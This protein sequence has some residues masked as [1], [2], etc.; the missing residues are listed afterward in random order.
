MIASRSGVPAVALEPPAGRPVQ[1]LALG[2]LSVDALGQLV[3]TRLTEPLTRPRLADLHRNTRGNP[4]F[5]LEIVRALNAETRPLHPGDP[6]P[7]PADVAA[8]LRA[9][10]EALSPAARDA[11]LLC[12]CTPHPSAPLL[13]ALA[14]A[15]L[16]EALTAEIVQQ[17]GERLGFTH[18]LL[19]SFVHGAAPREELRDAHARL[20][21]AAADPDD[22]ALH[23]AHAAEDADAEVAAE[24]EAAA[25]RAY[26]RGAPAAAAELEQHAHR[27][28]PAGLLPAA[29]LR[30]T[31]S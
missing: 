6:L 16:D 1:A 21:A 29:G 4:Y 18:P 12:A 15:G 7:I 5:A 13:R 23:L 19:G 8:L 26:R 22:R 27:L 2:P 11:A 28:T 30:S 25:L 9:R 14:G 10:I 24:L 17:D 3:E 20:A 31:S